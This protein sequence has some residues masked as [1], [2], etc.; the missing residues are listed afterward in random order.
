MQ[1][2]ASILYQLTF[3]ELIKTKEE[4]LKYQTLYIEAN[5]EINKLKGVDADAKKVD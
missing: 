1:I 4:A 2:D 3:Q 5:E